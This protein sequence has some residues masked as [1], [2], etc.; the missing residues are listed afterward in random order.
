MNMIKKQWNRI[1]YVLGLCILYLLLLTIGVNISLSFRNKLGIPD[2]SLFSIT[3]GIIIEVASYMI[4]I[5]IGLKNQQKN[6]ASICFFKKVNPRV[7]G[8]AILCYIGYT[9]FDYF[10]NF[11]YLSSVIDFNTKTSVTDSL[12]L[13]YVTYHAFFPAV[14][15]EILYKGLFFTI[16]RKHYSAIV[17]VIIVSLMFALSH[18]DFNIPFIFRSLFSC[19]TFWL[20]LRVGNL[21]LPIHLHFIRNF[22]IVFV[23]INKLFTYQL[24]FYIALSLLIIGSNLVYKFT[25]TEQNVSNLKTLDR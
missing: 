24:T 21:I 9:F 19:Y 12:F 13:F 20:Y 6:I 7:W 3:A 17:A 5:G 25:E 15:E 11:M 18:T 1:K 10:L 4:V 16:L 2:D 14:F 23:S 8:A 22:F